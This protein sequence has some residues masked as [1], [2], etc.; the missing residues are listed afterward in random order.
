[1]MQNFSDRLHKLS[2]GRATLIALVV[3]LLFTALVLPRQ[4]ANADAGG[5][6]SP[7]LSL[8]YSAGDVYRMAEAYGPA[9]RTD[10]IRVRFTFDL[11]RPVVYVAFLTTVISWLT[12]QAFTSQSLW[13][14]ANLVPVISALSDYSEN[15]TCY[16]RA[17]S[18]ARQP[19]LHEYPHVGRAPLRGQA[20][21]PGYLAN[22]A[23]S[24][25]HFHSCVVCAS[26]HDVYPENVAAALVIGRC[27]ART[28]GG[29]VLAPLFTFVRWIF[30]GGSFV[31]LMVALVAAVWTQ[32][33]RRWWYHAGVCTHRERSGA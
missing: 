27:P 7:D 11:I 19:N 2:T 6:G 23:G 16:P 31:I 32:A 28:P 29:D 9:G 20:V 3:F 10:Y 13:Q 30:V 1:M 8:I 18:R 15:G 5:A 26:E 4:A 22:F 17:D 25:Q 14:R 33:R 21:V 12:R 24:R